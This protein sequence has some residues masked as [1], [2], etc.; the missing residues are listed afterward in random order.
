[1]TNNR[2]N[3]YNVG[4]LRPIVAICLICGSISAVRGQQ[5]EW[6]IKSDGFFDNLEYSSPYRE[7]KTMDG[8]WVQPS[9]ALR[10]DERHSLHAGFGARANWGDGENL[11]DPTLELYYEYS[12]EP[13][14]F[15]FGVFSRDEMQGD[16]PTALISDSVRYY[17]PM[18]EGFLFQHK[19]GQ[20][21]V[22]AFVD[23]TGCRSKERREQFMA[24]V[25]GLLVKG[26]FQAGFQGYYYHYARRLDA[27]TDEYVRDYGVANFFVGLNLS[28]MTPL[29]SLVVRA[30]V[31][32][33]LERDRQFIND[34]DINPGFLFEATA[35]WRNLYL[36]NTFYAGR[37]EQSSGA[38]GVGEWY[39][40][41]SFYRSAVYDRTDFLFRFI[42]NRYVNAYVGLSTHFD[43]EG[44]FS[45]QQRLSVALN[46]GNMRHKH[47]RLPF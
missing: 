47:N 46:I 14:R 39:W 4:M 13:L 28:R 20:N 6:N 44:K 40:A 27:P 22:E 16:W 25:S 18:M 42:R 19:K 26:A 33:D 10:W 30:G 1:M 31:L 29:D 41:D 7:S 23:W 45:W 5:I 12:T 15:L 3:I 35:T 32:S 17:G 21:Y 8:L 43:D 2:Y 37:G 11:E 34:W 24:G 38:A 9:L 36:K